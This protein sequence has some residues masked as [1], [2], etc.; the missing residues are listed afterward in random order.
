MASQQEKRMVSCERRIALN[1]AYV[2]RG[3]RVK[4]KIPDAKGFWVNA[5]AVVPKRSVNG[6]CN[7]QTQLTSKVSKNSD[8]FSKTGHKC[9]LGPNGSE[10]FVFK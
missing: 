6:S 8:A 7:C 10:S 5:L 3:E 4:I 1:V 9:S 2:N